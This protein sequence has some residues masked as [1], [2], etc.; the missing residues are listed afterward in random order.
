MINLML[1]IDLINLIGWLRTAWQMR[2][3]KA[4][5]F[6]RRTPWPDG[7]SPNPPRPTGERSSHE[8]RRASVKQP[9]GSQLQERRKP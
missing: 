2:R 9:A 3:A 1:M 7:P 8:Q 4:H 5:P 6:R